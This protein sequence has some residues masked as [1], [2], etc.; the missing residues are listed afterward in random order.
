[1]RAPVVAIGDGALGFWAAVRDIWAETEEQ[2]C[3]LH[4][5]ANVLDKLPK[6][7]QPKAKKLLQ[8]AM[9]AEKKED[10]G[11]EL[12]RFQKTFGA[13]C[14]QGRRV[15]PTGAGQVARLLRLSR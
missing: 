7:V 13:K 3:W 5:L 12:E 15:T 4:K 14:P 2:K 1:M 10:A 11:R 6:R 8:E 9:N